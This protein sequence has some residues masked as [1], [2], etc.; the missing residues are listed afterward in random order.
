MHSLLNYMGDTMD[1][2]AISYMGIKNISERI[3]VEKEQ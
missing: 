2:T 1:K 3:S